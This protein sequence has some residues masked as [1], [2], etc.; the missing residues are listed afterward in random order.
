M[1][2]RHRLR[3]AK[4]AHPAAFTLVELLVVI[5][6]IGLLIALLL[7]AVQAAREAARRNQCANNLKQLALA[8]L[9]HESAKKF[10]PT[11]GWGHNWIGD[12]DAGLGQNQPGSWAY[13]IMFF[14]EA[15]KNIQQSSGLPW[16]GPGPNG[17]TK[18]QMNATMMGCGGTGALTPQQAAQNQNA[19]QPM[20]YCPSRRPAALY[21]GSVEGNISPNA[22][23]AIPPPS[24]SGNPW[25]PMA[26]TDYAGNGGSV[27]FNGNASTGCPWAVQDWAGSGGKCNGANDPN[28]NNTPTPPS[29][30]VGSSLA[31]YAAAIPP[32]ATY[33]WFLAPCLAPTSPGG[34]GRCPGISGTIAPPS[35]NFTGVIWYRSQVNLRQITDGTSKVYLIGEKYIDQLTATM[36]VDGN[37]D[38]DGVYSGQSEALIRLGASGGV[39]TPD[40][41]PQSA[42][43]V[44]QTDYYSQYLYP[45]VQ[46]SPVWP[47]E[48]QKQASSLGK[49]DFYAALRFGS[50]HAGGMNMAFCDGSVHTVIYEIDP[51]VHAMLSDRQD[52]LTVDATQYLGQ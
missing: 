43:T 35:T 5:A 14:M 42:A 19:V 1:S 11:G 48:A 52:G 12:P 10:L 51:T 39:Y 3:L 34:K 45:P 7:P 33:Y 21:Y 47:G 30:F 40:V 13:S 17:V 29:P 50:A 4:R 18:G 9:N 46:D 38:G 6:I 22:S 8:A 24:G 25:Y 49:Y 26:K 32:P 31:A 27:G 28:D 16:S 15:A 37:G 41:A 2:T 23:L 36:A 44:A 20:F